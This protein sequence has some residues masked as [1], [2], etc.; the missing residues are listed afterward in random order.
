MQGFNFIQRMLE[1]STQQTT[2]AASIR[3]DPGESQGNSLAEEFG[4]KAI[5]IDERK[6][7]R[8]AEKRG[9][10]AIGTLTVL[11]FAAE[12]IC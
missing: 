11:E 7:R 6:G 12:G 1:V 4:A 3:L 8:I 9:L 2:L 10:D 5:L